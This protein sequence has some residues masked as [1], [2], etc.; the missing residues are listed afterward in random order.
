MSTPFIFVLAIYI[1]IVLGYLAKLFFKEKIDDK[2]LVLFSVYFFQPFLA[3]WGILQKPIDLNLALAP[4]LFFFISSF[5]IGINIFLAR[6]LFKEPQERSIFTVASVIGNTGNLGVP[7]GIALFGEES[8]AYTTL[9]NLANVIIVYT[10]GVFF[11]SRGR[12]DI[13]TSIK[14]IFKLPML[15]FTLLAIALNLAHVKLP[16]PIDKSLQM[17]AYTSMVIQLIIFGTYLYS[18]KLRHL[19]LGLIAS[20]AVVKFFIVP[21][22]AWIVLVLLPIEE[23]TKKILFMELIMPLAVANVNL[24]ALYECKPIQV[25]AAVFITSLLFLGLI[26]FY[27]PILQHF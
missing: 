26:F 2:T 25:T 8:V 18:V 11:Y 7:L 1:F 20:I 5:I 16:M 12:F 14:N 17:G 24:A 13:T 19:Q 10:F 27:I 23:Y 22:I 15:W 21:I 4:L 6:A 9:I 3:L